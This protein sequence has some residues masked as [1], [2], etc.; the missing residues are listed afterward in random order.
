MRAAVTIESKAINKALPN[1]IHLQLARY[2][3]NVQKSI[4]TAPAEEGLFKSLLN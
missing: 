2:N 4:V 1:G 3:G